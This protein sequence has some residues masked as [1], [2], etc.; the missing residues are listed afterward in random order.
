[1]RNP[2]G[3][4]KC[5]NRKRWPYKLHK[6]PQIKEITITSLYFTERALDRIWKKQSSHAP[7]LGVNK[8]LF[9]DTNNSTTTGE[10]STPGDKG[11]ANR[12]R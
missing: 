6:D 4:K 5:I 12:A 3:P 2:K 8:N 7:P 1:M 9:Q 11:I 10:Y